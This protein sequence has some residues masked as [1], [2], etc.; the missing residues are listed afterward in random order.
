MRYEIKH[1]EEDKFEIKYIIE[2]LETITLEQFNKRLAKLQKLAKEVG[3]VQEGRI[4][5]LKAMQSEMLKIEK[6]SPR[7][8]KS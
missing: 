8:E 7:G 6:K 4:E 2:Y 3:P 1:T 5:E